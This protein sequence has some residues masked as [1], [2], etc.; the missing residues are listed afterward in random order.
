MEK[1]APLRSS[2][3]VYGALTMPQQMMKHLLG[4]LPCLF[5]PSLTFSSPSYTLPSFF[6][7]SSFPPFLVLAFLSFPPLSYLFLPSAKPYLP[8]VVLHFTTAPTVLPLEQAYLHTLPA[9]ESKRAFLLV[10]L[11][12]PSSFTP[13]IH[14]HPPTHTNTDVGTRKQNCGQILFMMGKGNIEIVSE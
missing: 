14:T 3:T 7:H 9:P 13:C 1:V 12:N 8:Y 4:F 11:C 2:M 5:H 10:S 6:F